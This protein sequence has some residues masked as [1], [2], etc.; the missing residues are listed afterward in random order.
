LAIAAA[1]GLVSSAAAQGAAGS[2]NGKSMV[3]PK[4][5]VVTTYVLTIAA[6]GK[7]GSMKFANRDAIP[8]RI[9]AMAGDSVVSEAGPYPSI[10]RPG[11]T[12]TLLR[13][14]AH[15]KGDAMWGTFEATYG[16]GDKVH[17]KT[18]ATRAK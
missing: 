17:G 11:Q 16:N 18:T 4:D 3:G 8:T 7:T 10:L 9:V 1:V 14:V 13:T 15:Y 2:W 5:S 6:D 12:V